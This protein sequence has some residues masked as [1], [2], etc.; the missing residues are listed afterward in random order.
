MIFLCN[1]IEL[2]F[3]KPILKQPMP[4]FL[5]LILSKLKGGGDFPNKLLLNTTIN[6]YFL[7]VGILLKHQNKRKRGRR[8]RVDKE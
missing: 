8:C 1:L 5:D 3:T 4:S 6:F 7:C 2:R